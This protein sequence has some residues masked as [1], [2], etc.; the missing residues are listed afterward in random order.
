MLH[1]QLTVMPT[2]LKDCKLQA[3]VHCLIDCC[4]GLSVTNDL[5]ACIHVSVAICERLPQ[6]LVDNHMLTSEEVMQLQDELQLKPE[7]EWLRLLYRLE[8]A[9]GCDWGMLHTCDLMSSLKAVS[10]T[11]CYLASSAGA[12]HRAEWWM[13]PMWWAAVQAI[14]TPPAVQSAASMT[15]QATW[16]RFLHSWSSPWGLR[17]LLTPSSLMRSSTLPERHS[18]CAA[19]PWILLACRSCDT[20]CD[21]QSQGLLRC[22]GYCWL[23]RVCVGQMSS[24]CQPA[25]LLNPSYKTSAAAACSSP[26]V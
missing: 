23:P 20:W 25:S 3:A 16:K 21:H 7:D 15:Q 9:A 18:R 22:R 8:A 2:S 6:V 4:P 24:V 14:A 5:F 17:P 10:I 19:W 12:I 26:C 11:A 13:Q 1:A